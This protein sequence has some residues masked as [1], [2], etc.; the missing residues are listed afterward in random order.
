MTTLHSL[1]E[2]TDGLER[3]PDAAAVIAH[4][5]GGAEVWSRGELA[6]GARA[7]AAGLGR[8]G[9][10]ESEVVGLL[11]PNRPQWV[12]AFLAI[13][14]A[15]AIAMPLSEHITAAELE[16]IVGH[17]G[18]RRIFTTRAF[19][20]TLSGLA[21]PAGGPPLTLIL[22]DEDTTDA[23]AAPA[24]APALQSWRA[25]AAGP[26]RRS[27]D[28]R[29][30]PAR[31]AGLHLGH[32]RHPQGGPAEPRQHRRQHRGA[33]ARAPRRPGRPRAAAAAAA[34]RL[35]AHGRAAHRARGRRRGGAAERDQRPRDRP[36]ARRVPLHHHGRRAAPVRGDAERD[37]AP[38]RRPEARAAGGRGSCSGCRSRCGAASAGASAAICSG[39]C[40]VAS[41][42]TCACS[43]RA[44]RGSS[45]RSPGASRG[46][47]G[48][49]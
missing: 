15:G 24:A 27:A 49:S 17:S 32:H 44:G 4:R 2:L 14:R 11:A 3:A 13:V 26:A 21:R 22:L 41:A 25:L 28:D 47:A 34:P 42:R 10:A 38:P 8:A 20:K 48:R 5:P 19:V 31:G 35:P 43:P 12:L 9:L 1:A 16:R 36:R 18:C 37:R 45:R 39:R 46:S 30:G 23:A 7:L 33:A 40:T 29:P 6:A